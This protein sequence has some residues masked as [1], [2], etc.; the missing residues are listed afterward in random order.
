MDRYEDISSYGSK[1][2]GVAQYGE[3]AGLLEDTVTG[4]NPEE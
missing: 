2:G 4:L 1:G 3:Y